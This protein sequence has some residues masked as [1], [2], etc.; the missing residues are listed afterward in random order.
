[1]HLSHRKHATL[2]VLVLAS[3]AQ[4]FVNVGAAGIKAEGYELLSDLLNGFLDNGG[5]T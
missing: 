1:L 3:I 5:K 2:Q 4:P